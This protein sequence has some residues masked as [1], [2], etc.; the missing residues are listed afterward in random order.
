MKQSCHL[1][2]QLCDHCRKPP[3][4]RGFSNRHMKRGVRFQK[5]CDAFCV[6]RHI[7][8]STGFIEHTQSRRINLAGGHACRCRLEHEPE[9]E[10]ILYVSKG[11]RR[12]PVTA[13][14][15]RTHQTIMRKPRQRHTHR[16]LAEPV[17]RA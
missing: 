4:A 11:N 13:A 8:R 14:W 5:T 10:H 12:H 3:V 17:L 16:R 6:V 2:E 7:T 1:L 9:L 15:N